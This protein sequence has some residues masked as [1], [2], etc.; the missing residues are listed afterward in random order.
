MSRINFV[1]SRVEH[2]KSIITLG[3][4]LLSYRIQLRGLKLQNL[5]LEKLFLVVS[6]LHLLNRHCSC[7]LIY[8]FVVGNGK[9]MISHDIAE[10][11]YNEHLKKIGTWKINA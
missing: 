3:S 9:N 4:G 2:E 11:N 7:R 6:K 1:L 8:I 5:K 10:K